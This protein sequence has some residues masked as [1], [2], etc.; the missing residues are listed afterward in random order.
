MRWGLLGALVALALAPAAQ[1]GGPTLTLGTAEDI[2][3]SS[4]LVEAKAQMTLLQLAGFR[5]VRVT[6]IWKPGELAPG[7]AERKVLDNVVAAAELS[8]IR[9]YVSVFHAGSRTTPLAP[10]DRAQFA[11]YAAGLA[12]AYPGVRDVIVGN[13]PNLNRFWLPQYAADGSGASAPAYLSLLAE[14]YDALKAVSRGITVVGGALAPRGADNPYATRHTHSPGLFLRELGQA[15]RASRR[16]KPIMDWLAFHPY[17]EHSSQPPEFRRHPRSKTIGLNDYG[18]LVK[19]LRQAFDG[20]RQR[21]AT[22]PILY[23]EYGIEAAVPFERADAY[24]GREHTTTRPVS[25]LTQGNFYRRALALAR[26][27]P[28]V[29]GFLLFLLTDEPALDRWQSGLLYPD[30][31]PKTSFAAVRDAVTSVRAPGSPCGLPPPPL[32]PPPGIAVI[33]PVAV[34][35]PVTPPVEPP[36]DEPVEPPAR[37]GGL[38]E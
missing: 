11:S 23:A 32:L 8:G 31:S 6:S 18:K 22:L 15:Y 5:A 37:L 33:P 36:P 14:T 10:E 2:V 17:G 3:R 20:T 12:R 24:T 1:A 4:S 16:R 27:Q 13:E 29:K 7:P 26:C 9:I 28:T 35:P 19:A 21:G 34:V 25:E 38:P 30:D